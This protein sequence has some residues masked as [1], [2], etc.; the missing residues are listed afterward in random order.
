MLL[1]M[2]KKCYYTQYHLL[3][4]QNSK[5]HNKC[6]PRTVSNSTDKMSTQLKFLCT[7]KVCLTWIQNVSV[8]TC[9]LKIFIS[10]HWEV[11]LV[12]LQI[13]DY[14]LIS[15]GI[16][17]VIG[18]TTVLTPHTTLAAQVWP[19]LPRY[20]S[21]TRPNSQRFLGEFDWI[22]RNAS[23]TFR[24]WFSDVHL[25]RLLKARTHSLSHLLHTCE[26]MSWTFGHRWRRWKVAVS[27]DSDV[28]CPPIWP[29]KKW[30]GVNGALSHIS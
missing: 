27:T 13:T 16:S 12:W 22:M 8:R 17:F 2:K 30:L 7:I 6:L 29:C 26:I 11:V 24:S 14:W 25:G 10:P 20:T 15:S 5:R 3:T 28:N 4:V 9:Y 18:L 23:S 1:K 19:S 21:V